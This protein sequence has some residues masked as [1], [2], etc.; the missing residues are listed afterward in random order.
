MPRYKRGGFAKSGLKK[1]YESVSRAMKDYHVSFH[2]PHHSYAQTQSHEN[3]IPVPDAEHAEPDIDH[4]VEDVVLD[5]EGRPMFTRND[6]REGRRVVE[7]GV[8]AD[9][10]SACKFCGHPLHLSHTLSIRTY[11][12][13]AIL[14]VKIMEDGKQKYRA[15]SYRALSSFPKNTIY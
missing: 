10:L 3:D 5:G 9:A 1:R 8:L 4:V 2:A 11:G 7:L 6:W 14:K 13:A 15:C 12:L